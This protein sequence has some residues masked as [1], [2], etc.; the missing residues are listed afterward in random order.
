MED[1]EKQ[2][3]I[4]FIILFYSHRNE[5]YYIPFTDIKAFYERSFTGGRKSFKYQEIDK[6]Y[7]LGKAPGALVHYLE[8]IQ[9]DLNRRSETE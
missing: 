4:S 7:K 3:G 6:S 8:G 1:F 9:K 2:G 5:I